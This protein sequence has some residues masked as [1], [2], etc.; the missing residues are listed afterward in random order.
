MQS[1]I[2]VYKLNEYA[3][4]ALP[5]SQCSTTWGTASQFSRSQLAIL[6]NCMYI[7]AQLHYQWPTAGVSP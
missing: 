5:R 3:A 1:Y 2:M 7:F 4:N 6:N